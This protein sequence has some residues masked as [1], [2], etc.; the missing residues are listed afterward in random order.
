M[1]FFAGFFAFA[2]LS[3]ATFFGAAFPTATFLPAA[4]FFG[5]AA[6][7]A[8]FARSA[9]LALTAAFA[10]PVGFPFFGAAGGFGIAGAMPGTSTATLRAAESRPV[11]HHSTKD[12]EPWNIAARAGS[13][14]RL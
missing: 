7:A 1:P 8:G 4:F 14:A 9:A 13:E 3:F 6:L 12:S 11:V 5:F 10:V 2:A